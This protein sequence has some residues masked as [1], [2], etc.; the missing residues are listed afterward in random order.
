MTRVLA[1]MRA[2]LAARRAARTYRP[3]CNLFGTVSA[4]RSHCASLSALAAHAWWWS[5]G[6]RSRSPSLRPLARPPT[7]LAAPPGRLSPPTTADRPTARRKHPAPPR[8]SPRCAHLDRGRLQGSCPPLPVQGGLRCTRGIG[9]RARM[10]GSR[11]QPIANAPP[12]KLGACCAAWQWSEGGKRR[13]QRGPGCSELTAAGRPPTAAGRRPSN[14]RRAAAH[15]A[16]QA[17]RLQRCPVCEGVSGR[18]AERER[19]VQ[20]GQGARCAVREPGG[21]APPA[22]ADLCFAPSTPRPLARAQMVEPRLGVDT[23]PLAQGYDAVCCFVNDELNK[24]VRARAEGRGSGCLAPLL[25]QSAGEPSAGCAAAGANASPPP[26]AAHKRSWK[27]WLPAASSLWRC[28]V[29]ALT[30]WTSR[31]ARPRASRWCA[32]R[33][34]RPAVWRSTRWR[35]CLRWPGAAG[36]WGR[37]LRLGWTPGGAGTPPLTHPASILLAHA[38]TQKPAKPGAARARGQLH[39]QRPGGL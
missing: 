36:A 9:F 4:S 33:P 39:P 32:C 26:P 15:H 16:I 3:P 29:P 12:S 19:G 30:R 22:P 38:H 23:A 6:V 10:P 24:E 20:R 35:S 5:Q 11:R 37:Q 28:A 13:R 7:P 2:R 18:A 25:G 1:R 8:R 34:T 17:H 27:S 21:R 31:P 14:G